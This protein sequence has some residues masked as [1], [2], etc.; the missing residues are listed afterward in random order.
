MAKIFIDTNVLIYSLDKADVIKRRRARKVLA[1]A[2][3][4]NAGV[5][6]T[7]VLQE[8]YVVAAKKLKLDPL[9]AKELV[10]SFEN[11]EVVTVTAELIR[12]AV[13]CSV[14]NR[15]SFWGALI[16]VA[17]E[18]AKC[19]ELWS[20]DFNHGQVVRGVKIVNPFFAD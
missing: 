11:F 3:R 20:E 17:A 14:L 9:V 1:E 10:R 8:F 13:D 7:Q 19:R 16:A 5:I 4:E 6:S 15:I 18:S 12:E 2:A